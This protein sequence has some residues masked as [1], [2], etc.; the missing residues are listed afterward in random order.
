MCT[1]L[2]SSN[3]EVTSGSRRSSMVVIEEKSVLQGV[4]PQLGPKRYCLL[5]KIKFLDGPSLIHILQ[6]RVRWRDIRPQDRALEVSKEEERRQLERRDEASMTSLDILGLEEESGHMS[7]IVRQ[8]QVAHGA[9]SNPPR[10]ADS[11]HGQ[12]RSMA[13]RGPA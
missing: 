8:A 6:R 11:T 12:G 9:A 1:I 10:S 5:G 7:D 13:Q 2:R 4:H 3:D